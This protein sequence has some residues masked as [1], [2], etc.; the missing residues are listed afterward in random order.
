MPDRLFEPREITR[1]TIYRGT[2]VPRQEDIIE[3]IKTSLKK[4]YPIELPREPKKTESREFI[5]GQISEEALERN[6]QRDALMKEYK[7][8]F[9]TQTE[10]GQ[11]KEW[12]EYI[13]T[14]ELKEL[15]DVYNEYQEWQ[16]TQFAEQLG[17]PSSYMEQMKSAYPPE[18]LESKMTVLGGWMNLMREKPT[19]GAYENIVALLSPEQEPTLEEDIRAGEIPADRLEALERLGLLPEGIEFKEKEP[20]VE[21]K[22]KEIMTVSSKIEAGEL[23]LKDLPIDYLLKYEMLNYVPTTDL[24]QQGFL[25]QEG[26]EAIAGEIQGGTP[27]EE[28]ITL[29]MET[30]GINENMAKLY[31][32]KAMEW[33]NE[34]QQ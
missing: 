34:R 15:E 33:I 21:E 26:I 30:Q 5:A 9:L 25:L 4:E 22:A 16:I 20:T 23:E 1:P 3:T 17:I 27:V 2:Q 18:E 32:L 6:R 8:Y 28:L 13:P 11:N 12:V 10:L 19:I 29:L 14:M 31:I 7:D 24:I